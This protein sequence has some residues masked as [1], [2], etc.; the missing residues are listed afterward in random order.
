VYLRDVAVLDPVKHAEV[1]Y[2]ARFLLESVRALSK[3]RPECVATIDALTA[4]VEMHVCKGPGADQRA[5]SCDA[6]ARGKEGK[7]APVP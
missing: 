3:S 5:E 1:E 2:A 6:I 7:P 4:A